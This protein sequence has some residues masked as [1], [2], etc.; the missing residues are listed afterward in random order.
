MLRATREFGLGKGGKPTITG[1]FVLLDDLKG[2]GLEV[3]QGMTYVDSF[4][5]NMDERSRE[6]AHR[7]MAEHRS[8]PSFSQ[9]ADYAYLRE[10][11]RMVKDMYLM[12][13]KKPSE[14]KGEWDLAKI[15][16]VIPGDD[17]FRPLADSRC[18]L[19]KK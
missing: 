3:A 4:Y 14:S 13:A 5:W 8:M 2:V 1:L 6:F 15:K 16:R 11:G 12:E 10:D 19:V 9:A 7:F 17:A 18:P